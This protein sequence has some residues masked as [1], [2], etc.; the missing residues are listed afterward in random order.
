MSKAAEL[1]R[2]R[3]KR[4]VYVDALAPQPG[5]TVADIVIRDPD[6]PPY[7]TTEFAR[8]PDRETLKNGLFSDLEPPLLEWALDRATLHPKAASSA[9]LTKFWSQSWPATVV[10]CALSRNPSEAH[11]RRTAAKLGA[12]L[13]RHER[14]PLP[15]AETTPRRRPAC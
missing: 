13:A 9:D 5:E 15:D 1:A 10:Y 2:D 8:G 3:I 12:R 14:R 6:D 11:Q 4:L 7:Q